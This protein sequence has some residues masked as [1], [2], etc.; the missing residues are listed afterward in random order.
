MAACGLSDAGFA[1]AFGMGILVTKSGYP[2]KS[3]SASDRYT[4]CL[5][6]VTACL[7]KLIVELLG[8]LSSARPI[9]HGGEQLHI[10]K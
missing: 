4:E 1:A 3:L 6:N 5:E 8:H 10:P 2:A 7:V 9:L